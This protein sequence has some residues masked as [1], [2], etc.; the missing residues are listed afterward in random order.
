MGNQLKEEDYFFKR[1]NDI[2]SKLTTL[3][4]FFPDELN[5]GEYY[6]K[7]GSLKRYCPKSRN[8]DNDIDKINS[9]C[10]WLFN[11]LYGDSTDFSNNEN[12]NIIIITFI[13][14]WLSYKLNQKAE[15]R[16]TKLNE[17]YN[18]HMQN[19]QEYNTSIE[20]NTK[21]KTYIDLI[22]INKELMDIDISVMSK[23]YGVFK[24]LCKMYNELSKT[25]INGEEYLKD[26]NDFVNN[27]NTLFNDKNSNLF[28]QIL[29]AASNDYNYIKRTLHVESVRNQFP[30]LITEKK[31]EMDVSPSGTTELGSENEMSGSE[32]SGSE[33]LDSEILDSEIL[34]SDSTSQSSSILNKLILI[35]FIFV[36]TLIL[37]G[38]A[39]KVNNNSIKKYIQ[40]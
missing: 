31:K 24:N 13:F 29:H 28:K 5:S 1:R 32:I 17:F 23:F 16:I 3:R 9:Y 20:N 30:E 21:Y 19:V 34:D 26:V 14:G 10:L 40:H 6:F 18:K 33:I 25:K 12:D 27:Y 37:L 2:C 38:I 39:Y 4:A 7:G 22:N 11:Q 15:N 36:A 8:C 35:P